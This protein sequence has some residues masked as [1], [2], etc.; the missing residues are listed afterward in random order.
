MKKEPAGTEAAGRAK[1]EPVGTEAVRCAR[2][3]P[4]G[5]EAAVRRAKKGP[6]KNNL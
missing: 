5:N 3:E 4:A 1:R 6:D 2:K